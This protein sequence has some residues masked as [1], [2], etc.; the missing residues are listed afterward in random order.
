MDGETRLSLYEFISESVT[1]GCLPDDFSLPEIADD[2]QIMWM[3]GAMDGVSIYHMGF[4]DLSDE[5]KTRMSKAV[6]A[7]SKRNFDE[8]DRLFCELGSDVRAI[9]SIDELQSYVIDHRE[10]LSADN[11]YEYAVHAVLHSSDRECVKYGL[12][13]LELFD[14]DGSDELKNVIRTLGLSDEF[15]I[16]AIFLMLRWENGNDE[17][18]RLVRRL[19]GWGRIHAIERIEPETDEIRDWLLKDGVHNR[20]LPAYSALTCWQKSD[21]ESVLK[22]CPTGEQFAGIRDIIDGLLDEGPVLGISAMEDGADRMIDF[23]N[24]ARRMNLKSEDYE[25]IRN[26][27][28]YYE[29]GDVENPEIVLLCQKILEC[30]GLQEEG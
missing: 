14:I 19:H 20:V 23:L 16:F 30:E 12:S 4:S 17:V 5:S 27:R 10:K 2:R 29:D 13:L 11:I 26:I 24:Q 22:G 3:D 18:Y 7:A 15:S 25:V 1:D 8:A 28:R 6:D 9:A 21:T